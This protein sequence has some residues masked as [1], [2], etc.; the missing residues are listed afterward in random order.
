MMTPAWYTWLLVTLSVGAMSSPPQTERQSEAY[1]VSPTGLPSGTGSLSRPWDLATALAGGRGRIEPG[2]TV[3]LHD[4]TYRGAFRTRL[5][6]AEDRHIVF[7]QRA[8]A[9]A[10][11]DGTLK[12]EGAY[13]T[14]WG[15]EIMQSTPATYGLEARTNHGRF[16]NLI[17]HDAGSMGVS[18]WT[19]GENAE[20]YGCIIYNNGTHENLDHGVYVHNERGT[21]VIADNVFFNNLAYGIHAYIGK[22]GVPQRNI[23]MDGNIAFNNG[24]ISRRYRAKGNILVGGELPM[25]GMQVSNNILYFSGT[26]GENLRIGY[27]P[28]T[29]GDVVVRDNFVWGGD[30][31]LLIG[32]WARAL[33]ERNTLGGARN[34]VTR[35]GPMPIERGTT[36]LA[37]S[38]TPAQP[39][40]FVRPNRYEQGRA[41]V[42]VYNWR[43]RASVKVDLSNVLRRG[44]RYEIRSVQDLFGEP[45]VR[46][47]YADD[48]VTV[49]MPRVA[50][51]PLL[52]RLTTVLAPHTT[53]AFDVFVVTATDD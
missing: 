51:P 1:H 26:A 10:T 38:R 11:I 39:T 17:I 31:A 24:T 16:I 9:R 5:S 7:R 19:P 8:G 53:P 33:L 34:L 49:P 27:A 25:S 32:T 13:L 42:A 37:A 52:G 41:H 30:V 35:A 3:W 14:F 50:P 2:D 46:G 43:A 29:N 36:L 45:V 22:S 18:F 28:I 20:L 48:S 23:V 44:Q 6:G 15:F 21:K 4:G 12:A 47:T 40:V